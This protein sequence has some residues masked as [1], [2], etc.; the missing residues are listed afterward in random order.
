MTP[1]CDDDIQRLMEEMRFAEALHLVHQRLRAVPS[2]WRDWYWAGACCRFLGDYSGAV[3]NYD[4]S[5]ELNPADAGIHTAR[6]IA[7]QLAERMDE[8]ITAF[9]AAIRLNADEVAAYNSLGLTLRKCG[10]LERAALI[11]DHGLR[12]LARLLVRRLRNDRS[13]PVID[14]RLTVGQLWSE[15]ARIGAAQSCQAVEGIASYA[16]PEQMVFSTEKLADFAGLYWTDIHWPGTGVVRCFLPNLM[17][18][19][20][21]LFRRELLYATL[22][23]NRG[24]VLGL[25][26]LDADAHR[27]LAEAIE[28]SGGR[29][30]GSG[31]S[32]LQ[33]R[34]GG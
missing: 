13:S 4:R 23:D 27:H 18:T 15:Y 29:G 21:E 22:L 31:Q 20:R 10:E 24:N 28:F 6:G 7:L 32:L 14:H 5:L 12:A 16:L 3:R 34:S 9:D 17:N 1:T 30:L 19:L 33:W 25:L 26:G 11:Y 2:S 8:A